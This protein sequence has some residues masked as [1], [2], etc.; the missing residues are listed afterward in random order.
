MTLGQ[1]LTLEESAF[2]PPTMEKSKFFET[3]ETPYFQLNLAKCVSNVIVQRSHKS[4]REF[5]RIQSYLFVL[6]IQKPALLRTPPS[7]KQKRNWLITQGI[8]MFKISN[9]NSRGSAFSIN[10]VIISDLDL[11]F[12]LYCFGNLWKS[13]AGIII[14]VYYSQIYYLPCRF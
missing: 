6:I 9:P 13:F 3:I 4:K 5:Q 7:S 11:P 1:D 8:C 12:Y 2:R 10:C 14:A